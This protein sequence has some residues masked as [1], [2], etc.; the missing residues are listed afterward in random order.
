MKISIVIPAYNQADVLEKSVK[1]LTRLLRRCKYSYEILIVEDGSTD[2]TYEIA[3]KLE[4]KNSRI[5]VLHSEKRRGK[6][7]ALKYAFSKSRGDVLIFNDADLSA[8]ISSLPDFVK[9]IEHGC[10]ICIG[11]RFLASSQLERSFSRNIASRS[12]NLLAKLLFNTKIIDLQCGFKAFKKEVLP[13]ILSAKNNGWAWDTEVLLLAE[14]RKL[15]ICQI[16]IVWKQDKKSKVSLFKD[17]PKFFVDL[18]KL[19]YDFSRRN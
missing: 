12:Y 3:K 7:G 15:K 6:G 19:K 17:S 4:S 13:V 10:D 1:N 2:G 14:K 18:I 5:K 9:K 16:P 11:C 8:Q